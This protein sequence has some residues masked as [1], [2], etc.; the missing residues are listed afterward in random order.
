MSKAECNVFKVNALVLWVW[1]SL[2]N[3]SFFILIKLTNLC[4]PYRVIPRT[5]YSFKIAPKCKRKLWC[6]LSPQFDFWTYCN[7]NYSH[8]LCLICEYSYIGWGIKSIFLRGIHISTRRV[9]SA[10]IKSDKNQIKI[11]PPHL[12]ERWFFLFACFEKKAPHLIF[13]SRG[14]VFFF[15]NLLAWCPI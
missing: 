12:V 11:L 7:W 10:Q 13:A 5:N 1:P 2:E 14:Q 4:W 3:V 15:S 8:W 9:L 6:A